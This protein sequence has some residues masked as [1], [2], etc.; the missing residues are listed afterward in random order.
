MI[1]S[2][3]KKPV[4]FIHTNIVLNTYIIIIGRY[5]ILKLRWWESRA[6]S[7]LFHYISILFKYFAVCKKPLFI[8]ESPPKF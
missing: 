3:H 5:L 6:S 2:E 4:P 1:S 8:K 7:A